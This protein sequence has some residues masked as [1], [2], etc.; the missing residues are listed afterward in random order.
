MSLLQVWLGQGISNL[1]FGSYEGI[2][3]AH[4]AFERAVDIAPCFASRLGHAMTASLIGKSN[5]AA[6]S[7]RKCMS[8][9]KTEFYFLFICLPLF[10]IPFPSEH[11]ENVDA[12]VV[13]GMIEESRGEWTAAETNFSQALQIIE[14]KQ[15]Q[16]MPICSSE[17][18]RSAVAGK[19]R[20]QVANG[21]DLEA[22][23]T[24]SAGKSAHILCQISIVPSTL[25]LFF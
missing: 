6:F 17:S 1:F 25:L 11:P 19:V 18:L 21:M 8:G 13:A 2:E 15:T 10:S 23:K 9:S 5:N 14:T 16:G 20:A 4:A 24:L 12:L 22:R 3:R 7:V